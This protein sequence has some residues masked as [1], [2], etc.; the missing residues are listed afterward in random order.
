MIDFSQPLAGLER[1][2]AQVEKTAERVAQSPQA[3]D[4]V[5]LSAEMISLIQAR[6]DTRTNAALVKTEDQIA[7]ALIDM[8]G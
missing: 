8:V 3:G 5:N 2:S 6:N 4:T 1:A 7:K